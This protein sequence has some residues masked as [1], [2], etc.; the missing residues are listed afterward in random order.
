MTI[1]SIYAIKE[2]RG[3][4]RFLNQDAP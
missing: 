2:H 4:V 1:N 3:T